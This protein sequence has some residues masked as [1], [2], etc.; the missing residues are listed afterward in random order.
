MTTLRSAR[1]KGKVDQFISKDSLVVVLS[2]LAAGC[3]QVDAAPDPHEE[4]AKA[5]VL[6]QLKDPESAKF[7][8]ITI[9]AG[10]GVVCGSVNARTPMGG[11]AGPQAWWYSPAT[12]E[13]YIIEAGGDPWSKA[14]DAKLF[15]KQGCRSGLEHMLPAAEDIKIPDR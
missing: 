5:A 3:G 15:Q 14:W 12:G 11:Y 2:L 4:I 13:T 6:S 7:G 8:P 9:A 10:T 1:E